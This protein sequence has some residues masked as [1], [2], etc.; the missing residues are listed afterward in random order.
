MCGA[1]GVN[2]PTALPVLL[3]K[4]TAHTGTITVLSCTTEVCASAPYNGHTTT[5]LPNAEFLRTIPV[6]K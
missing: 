6:V 1:A 4:S 5:K 2:N 3:Y